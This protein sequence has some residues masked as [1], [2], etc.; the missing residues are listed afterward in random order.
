LDVVRVDFDGSD[1][2]IATGKT[3]GMIKVMVVKGRPVGASIVGAGAGELIGIW[4]MALANNLKISAIAA[5]V[6]A[7]SHDGGDQQKG[8]RR[9]FFAETV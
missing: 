7:L 2:A 6:L 5:M 1:R 8:C 4:A 3:T 9:L